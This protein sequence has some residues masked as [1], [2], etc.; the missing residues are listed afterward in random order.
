M[1][2]KDT[3]RKAVL[4]P[5]HKKALVT[6]VF[7][8]ALVLL[9]LSGWLWARSADTLQDRHART[10]SASA[11]LKTTYLTP[12]I[13]D[14]A[15]PPAPENAAEAVT[16]PTLPVTA[17]ENLPPDPVSAPAVVSSARIAIVMTGLGMSQSATERALEDLPA[18]VALAY[19]VYAPQLQE[20]LA[21][22]QKAGRETLLEVP[23]EPAG[24]PRN[25]PGSKSLL[26]RLS[27]EENEKT[28]RGVLNAGKGVAGTI[29]FQGGAYLA[30]EASLDTAFP[31]LKKAGVYFVEQAQAGKVS[32][33]AH[34]AERYQLPYLNALIKIDRSATESDIAQQLVEVEKQAR[35]Q[36]I[37]AATVEPYPITFN[38]LKKWQVTLEKRGF[39]L[40]EPSA[41]LKGQKAPDVRPH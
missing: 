8:W 32:L 24:Y 29:N 34:I 3:P 14:T 2:D 27:Q 13:T 20:Q 31:L 10:P 25:D 16:A 12:Q 15:L 38:M 9:F 11:T 7:A 40:V 41:L 28:L 26:T 5:G 23:M 6:G 1:A 30:D 19:S 36:G 33:G 18:H 39:T 37:A 35:T 21:A 17:D 4:P 22:A